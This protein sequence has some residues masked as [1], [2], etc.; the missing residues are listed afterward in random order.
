MDKLV[1]IYF[2][3]RFILSAWQTFAV[4]TPSDHLLMNFALYLDYEQGCLNSIIG[5]L[6]KLC[7]GAPTYTAI[8]RN[9]NV[10]GR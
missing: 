7:T 2:T 3:S 6:A 8:H 5:T 1:N 9:K 4:S 10:N